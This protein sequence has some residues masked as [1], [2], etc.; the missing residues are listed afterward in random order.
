MLQVLCFAHGEGLVLPMPNIIIEDIKM[1]EQEGSIQKHHQASTHVCETRMNFTDGVPKAD[2]K[3]SQTCESLSNLV[4][5]LHSDECEIDAN[6][7]KVIVP[8]PF[9]G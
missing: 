3:R 9:C 4:H 2:S 6:A 7:A 1:L 8:F 5:C